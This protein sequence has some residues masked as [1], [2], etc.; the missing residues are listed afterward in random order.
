MTTPLPAADPRVEQVRALV[1]PLER[2]IP[3]HFADANGHMN[4]VRYLELHNDAAWI[5]M[6]DFGLGEEHATAGTAGSFQ[7]EQHMTYLREVHVGD[8]VAVH[9]R[10][11]ERSAKAIHLVQ[12]LVNLTRGDVAN[13]FESLS[14][15]VDLATR[16]VV[17]FPQHVAELLDAQLA[18]DRALDW[19][20]PLASVIRVR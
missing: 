17:P 9:V 8:T 12:F 3:E 11:V 7:T 13:T 1:C 10:M 20:V 14:L 4:I 5:H 6:H 19:P 15:S 2:V 16:K 18:I